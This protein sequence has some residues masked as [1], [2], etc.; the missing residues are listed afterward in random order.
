M[1]PRMRNCLCS[2]A[3]YL[4]CMESRDNV[5]YLDKEVV[6]EVVTRRRWQPKAWHLHV[7]S[8]S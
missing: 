4:Y 2:Y 6:R 3:L 1:I 5:R 8:M 7:P